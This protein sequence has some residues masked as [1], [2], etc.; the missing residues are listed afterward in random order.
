MKPEEYWNQVFK[1]SDYVKGAKYSASDIIG[2]PLRTKLKKKYPNHDDVKVN[3][4][5]S[6]FVGSAIHMRCEAWLNAENDFGETNMQSEVKLLYKGISGTADIIYDGYIIADIKTGGE[7]TIKSKIKKPEA[8]SKQLS[9]YSLLNH[10][11]N[12]TK[13]GEYGF[14]HWYTTDTKKFGTIKV[15]LYTLEEIT[16]I[17][18]EFMAE[19]KVP[20]E[21]TAKCKDCSWLWRWCSSRSKC[22][23]YVED[24]MSAI[25]DW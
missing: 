16:N 20:I 9:I 22:S 19:M 18:K 24:D 7:S 21:E 13:Y 25:T 5:T 3:E 11:Q 1:Y 10:K 6:S 12:K 2:E 14:I 8:W 4:K 23:Y 17:I 15:E